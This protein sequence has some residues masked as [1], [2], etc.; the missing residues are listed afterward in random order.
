MVLAASWVGRDEKTR[1]PVSAALMA[2]E[3]AS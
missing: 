1:C 3:V 2:I